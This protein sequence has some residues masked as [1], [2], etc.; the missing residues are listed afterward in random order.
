L[1]RVSKRGYAA[2]DSCHGE[3]GIPTDKSTPLIWGQQQGYID[4]ALSDFKRGRRVS[5]PMAASVQDLGRLDLVA[6]SAHYAQKPWPDLQQPAAPSEI[7]QRAEQLISQG[8]CT[9]SGCHVGFVGELAR[10]RVAGQSEE[11]LKAALKAY[12]NKTRTH[13][14]MEEA[15][16]SMS[17]ADIQAL[18]TYLA[19]LKP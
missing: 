1:L 17:D 14:A 10:P 12:Q 7:A 18:A 13:A 8:Q 19:G 15:V 9:E 3:Q 2:V 11:Y 6:I 16:R 5:E 4:A